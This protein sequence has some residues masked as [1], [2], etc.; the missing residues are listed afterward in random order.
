ML[1]SLH[2]PAEITA[3]SKVDISRVARLFR[4]QFC[5]SAVRRNAVTP[6]MLPCIVAGIF[7]RKVPRV[8]CPSRSPSVR[9]ARSHSLPVAPARPSA[10]STSARCEP[11]LVFPLLPGPSTRP[12]W[13]SAASN[14][15]RCEPILA[16]PLLPGPSTCPAWPSAGSVSARCEPI[17]AFPLLPGPSTCPA[18]PSAGSVSARCEPILAFPLPPGPSTCPARLSAAPVA[19]R[20]EPFPT[21]RL[22]PASCDSGCWPGTMA[23]GA[24]E[25]AASCDAFVLSRRLPAPDAPPIRTSPLCLIAKPF[26]EPSPNHGPVLGRNC[27]C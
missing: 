10:A 19:S 27:R 25:R 5:R 20:C 6:D 7:W 2:M 9:P 11:I 14:S 12:A 21:N 24:R 18:W 4:A 26:P 3:C 23:A 8:P 15:A 22:T 16:F 13:L 1:P 17:L